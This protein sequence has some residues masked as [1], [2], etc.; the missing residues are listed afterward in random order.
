MRT[1][2]YFRLGPGLLVTAAFIG[3]GTVT[4]ATL[5]GANYGYALLWAVLFSTL[6]TIILQEMSARLGLVTRS[7]LGE[8][9]RA[10][11]THPFLR[12]ASIFLVVAAIAF[13]NAAF[14]TGNI[15]G[16][17]L[18]LEA[19][20]GVGHNVWSLLVGIA[21]FLM[22]WTARYRWIERVLIALV[23]VMSVVFLVTAIQ[24]RPSLSQLS[25]GLF[26]PRIP[27]GSLTTV[28]ALIG[29]TVV[30][31][32]LFLHA[33][34]VREKWRADI[35]IAESL[36]D[37]RFDTVLSISLGGLVTL[38]IAVTAAAFL[39]SGATLTSAAS[40]AAQLEPVLG[41]WAK[42]FF[43]IGL[44]AAG[45]TS[46]ITAP[47]AAAYATS[48]ALGLSPDLRSRHFRAVW[49]AILMAGTVTA[50][51]VGKSPIPAIVFAQAANGLILPLIAVFLLVAVNQRRLMNEHANGRLANLLGFL[52]TLVVTGLGAY[53]IYDA[54][55]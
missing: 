19:V 36:R 24:S 40:M 4:S 23:V 5:A 32:N 6:A 16:A 22:L 29:T 52:V 20:S 13:G 28:I 45:M 33:S 30:P 43:A 38:A 51:A 31:Y 35:P 47:L 53:K 21:A 8:A 14:Q 18:G 49:I 3:P 39:Q 46:A 42:A 54:C 37:S 26:H 11:I 7:G 34:S 48:G 1:R 55:L 25:D 2:S 10:A 15:T 27:E 12:G 41:R 9:L 44:F 50:F 17:A